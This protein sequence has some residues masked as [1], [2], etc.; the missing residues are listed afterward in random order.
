MTNFNLEDLDAR[1]DSHYYLTLDFPDALTL[2]VERLRV[3]GRYPELGQMVAKTI[4]LYRRAV[5][6]LGTTAEI[7]HDYY[8]LTGSA[9]ALADLVNA[10]ESF[11]FNMSSFMNE[12]MAS[13]LD[14]NPLNFLHQLEKNLPLVRTARMNA[15]EALVMA[16]LNYADEM[17]RICDVD[18]VM[19]H[20]V[21]EVEKA[22]EL[23]RDFEDRLRERRTNAE[24]A[25]LEKKLAATLNWVEELAI[26][27]TDTVRR[28]CSNLGNPL[29]DT[30]FLSYVCWLQRARAAQ[31]WANDLWGVA[32]ESCVRRGID[33]YVR[34]RVV[35]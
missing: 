30:Q 35:E 26:C 10:R 13:A 15:F 5:T 20:E 7:C 34:L 17:A 4:A 28:Y 8:Y 3:N 1:S 24:L 11:Q 6:D 2:L 18:K 12:L 33:K 31:R 27:A 14:R 9:A 16:E 25:D 21:G 22:E 19:A 23:L 32:Y 29:D